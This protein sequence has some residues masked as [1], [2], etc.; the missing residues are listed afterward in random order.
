MKRMKSLALAVAAS[1]SLGLAQAEDRVLLVGVGDYQQDAVTDLP[2][3]DLDIGIMKEVAENLGFAP[4]GMKVL[5]DREATL[6][7]VKSAMESWLNVG[8]EDRVLIYFSSHGS[9]VPDENGDEPDNA[10]ETLLMHDTAVVR[11]N[12]RNTLD[13]VLVDDEFNKILGKL[14]SKNVLV[15][16]DACHSG[17]STKAMSLSSKQFGANE[18]VGKYFIYPGMPKGDALA[19]GPSSRGFMAERKQESAPA[20]GGGHVAITAAR[21]DET[22]LASNRGSIFTLGI[23]E[24][25]AKAKA[26]GDR[27]LT[28]RQLW[29]YAKNFVSSK[30]P[31]SRV[32]HPQINGDQALMDRPLFLAATSSGRGPVWRKVEQ[33]AEGGGLRVLV[34]K[35]TYV[36]GDK[37]VMRV[38][39]PEEGYLNL[40]NVGPDD[41]PTVLFPNQFHQDNKV[42]AGTVSLPTEKMDFDLVARAPYGANLLVAVVT[43]TPLNLFQSADGERNT[44]GDVT[45]S[46]GRLSEQGVA[47]TRGFKAESR[48]SSDYRG[49]KVETRICRD[50]S[51]CN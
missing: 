41:V 32:F 15:I 18:V 13:N 8:P 35:K 34:D 51:S 44:K 26:E 28:P 27:T 9:P 6:V 36:E 2:G 39:I 16:V 33:L 25:V 42:A 17:T 1:L 48:R 38:Q 19:G 10:D 30:L 7:N 23:Q 37:M 21:D 50:A 14:R 11:R 12:G 4:S 31:A 20:G 40:I 46:F 5:L 29:E 43:K 22:S 3:I 24:A 45:E 49:G 47:A